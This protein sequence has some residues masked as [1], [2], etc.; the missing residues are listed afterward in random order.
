MVLVISVDVYDDGYYV[1]VVGTQSHRVFNKFTISLCVR[2]YQT[3]SQM[4]SK[5][6]ALLDQI[7]RP[8]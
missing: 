6:G 1:S 4:R 5:V 3:V 8:A 2:D 7:Y